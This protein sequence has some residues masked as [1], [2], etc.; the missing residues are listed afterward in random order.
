MYPNV[1][2]INFTKG[3]G[4]VLT[5]VNTVTS[6]WFSRMFLISIYLII[7]FGVYYFRDDLAEGVATAGFICLVIGV[8]MKIAGFIGFLEIT[9]LTAIFIVGMIILWVSRDEG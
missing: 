7:M 5:Y 4:E 9:I 3:S 2:D 6:S 1:T 8:M